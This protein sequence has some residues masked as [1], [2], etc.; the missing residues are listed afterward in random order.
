MLMV[1]DANSI[2]LDPFERAHRPSQFALAFLLRPEMP[3]HS[4]T[5]SQQL[6]IVEDSPLSTEEVDMMSHSMR[7]VNVDHPHYQWNYTMGQRQ[8]KSWIP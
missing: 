5:S 1:F 4:R 2:W 7:P 6:V 8:P 3:L